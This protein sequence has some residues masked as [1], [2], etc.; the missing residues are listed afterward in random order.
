M[1]KKWLGVL[2][3]VSLSAGTAAAD[4][5]DVQTNSDNTRASTYNELLH[6]DEQVHD[7][8]ALQGP[9]PDEDWFR[10][11]QVPRTSWEVVVDGVSGDIKLGA[12]GVTRLS[13]TGVVIQE[14]S[15]AVSG[16]SGYTRTLRWLNASTTAA[17][18]E[19]VRVGSAVCTTDCR[20]D[21]QYTIRFRQTTVNVARF[22]QNGGQST[23]LLTQN[24]SDRIAFARYYFWDEAGTLLHEVASPALPP[25]RLY[26]ESLGAIGAL[27]GR[28]GHITITHDAGYG[29][30]NVKAVAL[31]PAT[32]FT[33][34]TPG[35]YVP[36]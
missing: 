33:F 19:F 27:A 36:H 5:W 11:P 1:V 29:G 13:P 17:N 14:S 10:V 28:S 2:A 15:A 8:G 18:Q 34:D 21:D 22:N 25:K 6:G 26:V 31:E 35:T 16:T 4:V 23:V 7:L 24:V 9:S 20:A 32:G 30:L 12:A 3:A